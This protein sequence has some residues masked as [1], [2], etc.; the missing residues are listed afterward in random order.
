[1]TSPVER[2]SGP[3][4]MSTPGKRAKGNTASLTAIW[5]VGLV[6]QM[7]SDFSGTPA[8]TLAA[9]AAI[10]QA[11]GLGDEGHGAAGARV[12]FEH[13]DARVVAESASMA[14][15]TFIRPR[16]SAR[17]HG[18]GLALQ[19]GD[20]GLG[21]QREGRQRAGAVA[22]VDPGFLDMLHDAGDEG[23]RPSHRASTST[24]VARFR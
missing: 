4:M 14:N 2:I 22:G 17:G 10:G 1:M 6:V 21:R 15:C 3:R 18:L 9:M 7:P 8:M 5:F 19:L 23:S 13:E 20:N 16:P 11:D 12:D 24:S